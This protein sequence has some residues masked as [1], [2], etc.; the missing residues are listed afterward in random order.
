[1]PLAG[2]QMVLEPGK[3]EGNAQPPCRRRPMAL[4]RQRHRHR[5][6]QRR[7]PSARGEC[8]AAHRARRPARDP[9]R[10]RRGPR[11]AQLLRA[12]RLHRRRRR[13]AGG[14]AGRKSEVANRR[15]CLFACCFTCA[16][17][18]GAPSDAVDAH[19]AQNTATAAAMA[20]TK[21]E[22]MLRM[23]TSPWVVPTLHPMSASAKRNRLPTKRRRCR[24][25]LGARDK[26]W[27]RLPC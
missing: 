15:Y 14:Q 21:R 4:R 25:T 11:D 16:G 8:A 20:T 23:T 7:A 1:M 22:P 3:A 24:Q 26:T 13:A 27:P 6:R 12:A 2:G 5:D 9:Q 10:R 18:C 19:P 17:E